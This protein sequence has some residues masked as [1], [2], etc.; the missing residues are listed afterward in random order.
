MSTVLPPP[1]A[2][3]LLALP[4]LL[5]LLQPTAAK[6]IA[7][8][9]AIPLVRLMIFLSW[10]EVVGCGSR[11]WSVLRSPYSGPTAQGVG[12]GQDL[13]P[14]ECRRGHLGRPFPHTGAEPSSPPSIRRTPARSVCVYSTKPIARL[15]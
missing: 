15:L 4:L 10:F 9:T 1:A 7:A 13:G 5:L 14:G 8:K 12:S 6:A 3:L 2:G 11:R